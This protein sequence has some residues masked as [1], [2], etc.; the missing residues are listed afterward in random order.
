M[1]T[2]SLKDDDTIAINYMYFSF[3]EYNCAVGV[4]ETSNAEEVVDKGLHDITII[5]PRW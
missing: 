5:G 2:K 1:F 3:G 4:A